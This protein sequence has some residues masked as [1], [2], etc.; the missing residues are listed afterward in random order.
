MKDKILKRPSLEQSDI[1]MEDQ[2]AENRAKIQGEDEIR[3]LEIRLR[4]KPS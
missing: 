1:E 4:E 2:Q 3:Y